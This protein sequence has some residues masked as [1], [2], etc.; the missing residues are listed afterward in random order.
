MLIEELQNPNCS[1]HLPRI[2]LLIRWNWIGIIKHFETVVGFE[3]TSIEEELLDKFVPDDVCS[4][5]YGSIDIL[6]NKGR[7]KMR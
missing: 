5:K 4:M 7:A 1:Y 2:H 6:L 3:I